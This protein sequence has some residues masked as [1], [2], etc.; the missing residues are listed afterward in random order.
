MTLQELKYR[1]LLKLNVVAA[2][3]V[4]N[5]DDGATVLTRYQALHA[6]LS[7]QELTDWH[8]AEDVPAE[9]ETPIVAMVAAECAPDFGNPDPAI[10][11]DGKFGLPQPSPQERL[12]RRLMATTYVSSPVQTEYY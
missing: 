10:V 8:V 11:L 5:P 3:D 2:G 9:F 4:P 6:T 12:L 1:V 7:A